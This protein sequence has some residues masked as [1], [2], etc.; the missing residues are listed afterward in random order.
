MPL[1]VAAAAVVVAGTAA[2]GPAVFTPFSFGGLQPAPGASERFRTP[3]PP[4]PPA[5]PVDLAGDPVLRTA[6]TVLV[7]VVAAVVLISVV[8][9]L[10]LALRDRGRRTGVRGLVTGS[11]V[12]VAETADAPAVLRGIAA[13][14]ASI[15]EDR[16]PGDAVVRA[17]LGL[18]QAAE[19]AGF[20]RSPA[21]TPTEF[22]G[23]V[24]SRT[25]ADR[26]ALG[27]LLRLYL[28]ARFG[29]GGI[30]AADTADARRALL[31]LEASW[32]LQDATGGTA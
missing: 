11:A 21:E 15:D 5:Q 29:D 27:A 18:Q 16:E 2:S 8:R 22:T 10:V 14:L 19:D 23:R 13:A 20:A 28:G 7:W 3:P 30:T 6:L 32:Q 17:W 1:V 26:A 24:L 9:L 25:G 31:A 12:P 4:R